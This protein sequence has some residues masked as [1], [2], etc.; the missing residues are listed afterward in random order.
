MIDSALSAAQDVLSE[1]TRIDH[2]MLRFCTIR[3]FSMSCRVLASVCGSRE[4]CLR[5]ARA[6]R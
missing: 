1:R 3:E 4:A 2:T 6:L 5:N